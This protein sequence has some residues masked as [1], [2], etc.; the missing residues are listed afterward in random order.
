MKI[1]RGNADL[2][3]EKAECVLT[4]S[5]AGF[6][7]R[8]AGLMLTY[9][10]AGSSVLALPVFLHVWLGVGPSI[11]QVVDDPPPILDVPPQGVAE[12]REIL[13]STTAA[14]QP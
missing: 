5:K 12:L 6:R 11:G 1:G 7:R 4:H 8:L 10:N 9:S 14:P 3:R 13:T 2:R